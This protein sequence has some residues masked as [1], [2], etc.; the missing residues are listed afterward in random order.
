M[1]VREILS[2]R[3]KRHIYIPKRRVY[4]DEIDTWDMYCMINYFFL[5][6]VFSFKAL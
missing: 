6:K 3:M 2:G 5:F 1:W 4:S